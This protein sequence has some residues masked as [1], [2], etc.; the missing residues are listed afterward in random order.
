MIDMD[1]DMAMKGILEDI[2]RELGDY[3]SDEMLSGYLNMLAVRYNHQLEDIGMEP[4]QYCNKYDVCIE[5]NTTR[6]EI[7]VWRDDMSSLLFRIYEGDLPNYLDLTDIY[8]LRHYIEENYSTEI[9]DLLGE[10]Y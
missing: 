10:G 7:E 3:N 9:E 4:I 2:V 5:Y 8:E 6:G 1:K